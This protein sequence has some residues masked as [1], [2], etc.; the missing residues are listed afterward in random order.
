M[1]SVPACKPSL[2]GRV[3]KH[4][5]QPRKGRKYYVSELKSLRSLFVLRLT[6]ERRQAQGYNPSVKEQG[7]KAKAM[8]DSR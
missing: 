4:P 1:P 3:Q 5:L 6:V 2:E 7:I 8:V